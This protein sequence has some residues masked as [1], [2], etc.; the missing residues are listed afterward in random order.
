MMEDCIYQNLSARQWAEKT[1]RLD[2]EIADI[3]SQLNIYKP[4]LL[5]L[6]DIHRN[7][8]NLMSTKLVVFNVL[9]IFSRFDILI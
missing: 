8:S 9:N 3:R 5:R 1:F 2:E 7:I 4:L 6:V